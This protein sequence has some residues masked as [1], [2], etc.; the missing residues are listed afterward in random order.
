MLEDLDK[1]S[2]RSA[3]STRLSDSNSNSNSK[4]NSRDHNGSGSSDDSDYDNFGGR[5]ERNESS[6]GDAGEDGDGGDTATED[7][8]T[9]LAQERMSSGSS[10][11]SETNTNGD[12]ANGGSPESDVP[13]A[14]K[15]RAANG[16]VR[17]KTLKG[18]KKSIWNPFRLIRFGSA[19][20]IDKSKQQ[21]AA[22]RA[23]NEGISSSSNSSSA[24][25]VVLATTASSHPVAPNRAVA[26]PKSTAVAP[27]LQ[28]TSTGT[29]RKSQSLALSERRP[30]DSNF[31]ARVERALSFPDP[32]ESQS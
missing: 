29:A 22:A 21:A 15:Q 7:T 8:T 28:A 18:V 27:V 16:K 5:G 4:S 24:E 26:R 20:T 1:L 6:A 23:E 30:S 25:T 14:G 11:Q 12:S 32:T 31:L 3:R 9:A 10:V 19:Q 17:A 2:N 13:V